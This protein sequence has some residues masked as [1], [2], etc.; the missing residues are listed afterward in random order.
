[1]QESSLPCFPVLTSES[2]AM[3]FLLHSVFS[4]SRMHFYNPVSKIIPF[5]LIPICG[6]KTSVFV[7]VLELLQNFSLYSEFSSH[8]PVQVNL[9]M[10]KLRAW[11]LC[12]VPWKHCFPRA[13]TPHNYS[14]PLH[15]RLLRPRIETSVNFRRK[16]LWSRHFPS[17]ITLLCCHHKYM[18]CWKLKTYCSLY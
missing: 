10:L 8:S 9:R 14:L 3:Q 7:W 4:R 5:L 6:S 2:Q 13:T 1:M 17:P 16:Y 15:S 18:R 12:P 11:H